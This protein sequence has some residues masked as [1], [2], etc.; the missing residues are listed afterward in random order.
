MGRHS[1]AERKNR[2]AQ[3]K[4]I[5][6]V[7]VWT[8]DR[9]QF[10]FMQI[11]RGECAEPQSDESNDR[12]DGHKF[13]RRPRKHK[14]KHGENI[15]EPYAPSRDQRRNI[16]HAASRRLRNASRT[17]STVMCNRDSSVSKFRL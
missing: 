4:W 13:W 17:S 14:H 7:R 16:A 12:A 5:S 11:S 3:I 8:T 6:R 15:A 10:L 1:R 9:Q 2:T